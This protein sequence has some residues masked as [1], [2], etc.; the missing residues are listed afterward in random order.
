MERDQATASDDDLFVL[1]SLPPTRF[2]KYLASAVVLCILIVAFLVMWPLSGV[3]LR[4]IAAI[5][6]MYLMAT[7]LCDSLTATLLFAKF[8]ISRSLA[9]LVIASGYLFTSIAIIPYSLTFPGIFATEPLIGQLQSTAWLFILWH[10]GFPLFAIVYGLLKDAGPGKRLWPGT[11]PSAIALSFV[12]IVAAVSVATFFSVAFEDYSPV[13]ILDNRR[14]S[15]LFPYYV[16]LPVVLAS[17]AAIIVLWARRQSLLDIWLMVVLFLYVVEMP[18]SIY[19]DPERF[20]L[21]WTAARIIGVFD[22]SVVLVVLLYEI[23][24]LYTDLLRAVRAQR[25]EREARLMTGDAVAAAIAHEAKQ[26]LTAIVNRANVAARWLQRPEPDLN[27]AVVAL[28]KIA[29]DGYRAATM[30]HGIRGSFQK[31]VQTRTA[32][33][34]NGLIN[35]TLEL[36]RDDLHRHEI[37]LEVSVDTKAL[38]I[39][40]DRIQLQEVLLNLIQNAVDAMVPVQGRRVLSILAADRA[41]VGIVVS[42]ADNGTGIDQRDIERVFDP[43]F[44]TK[45]DGKG[46]GLSICRLIVEAHDGKIWA[47]RNKPSGVIF[48]FAMPTET[49]TASV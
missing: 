30:I 9:N 18:I 5:L 2:Q 49:V 27:R 41:E 25:R 8:S 3:K 38:H 47:R 17:L 48:E 4:P 15:S 46:L 44:T 42:V 45:A 19:P 39:F 34:I 20:S 29:A 12:S 23:I 22:S 36:I 31:D 10:V 32:I 37:H 6:P 26:P 33:D 24:Y 13:I 35:D 28:Q 16:G 43:S 21:G 11:V 40:G 1:S 14:F 7:F